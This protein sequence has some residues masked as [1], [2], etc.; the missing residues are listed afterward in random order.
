MLWQQAL[1]RSVTALMKLAVII[2]VVIMIN[3]C[4]HVTAHCIL[5]KSSECALFFDGGLGIG[6]LFVGFF[7]WF[8]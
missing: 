3:L 5:M 6:K 1:Y 7:T 4:A 2:V 8:A